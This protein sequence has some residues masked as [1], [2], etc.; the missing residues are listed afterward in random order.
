ML[1]LTNMEAGD[2]ATI[3]PQSEDISVPGYTRASY[4]RWLMDGGPAFTVK[5]GDFTVGCLGVVEQWDGRWMAWAVL[6][7]ASGPFMLGLTRL[8][9]RFY[10]KFLADPGNRRIE[11]YVDEAFEP[12]MR[13]V[14][15]LGFELESRHPDGR[16]R[17]MR[18]FYQNG[19]AAYLYARTRPD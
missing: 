16:P 12:G 6:D 2:L 14:E 9:H 4:E 10:A 19:N 15:L 3:N 8:A 7:K 18:N 17:A 5:A 11:A 1:T 13:W